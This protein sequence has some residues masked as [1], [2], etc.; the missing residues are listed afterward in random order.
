MTDELVLP[1]AELAEIPAEKLRDYAL[2]PA[3]TT[4]SHKA[5]LFAAVLGIEQSGWTYLRDR[6]LEQLPGS[7]VTAIRPKP[8]WGKE[9]EVRMMDGLN[10]VTHPVITGWLVPEDGAPRLITAYLEVPR[11]G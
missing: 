6:I 10:G 3:H 1:R 8:P 4:G 5:R 7:P 9:Y 2:D 11:R